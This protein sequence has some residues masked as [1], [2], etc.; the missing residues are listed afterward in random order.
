MGSGGLSKR[1][2]TELG[3]KRGKGFEGTEEGV[4]SLP[5]SLA[6]LA[7]GSQ[8]MPAGV[9]HWDKAVGG[10]KVVSRGRSVRRT[11]SVGRGRGN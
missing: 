10:R 2:G 7:P 6:G 4:A 11:G 8:E 3:R 9:G 1:S 5:A